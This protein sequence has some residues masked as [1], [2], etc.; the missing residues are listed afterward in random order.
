[1]YFSYCDKDCVYLVYI[2]KK[3]SQNL[4]F[5]INRNLIKKIYPFSIFAYYNIRV[6]EM[7]VTCRITTCYYT[8]HVYSAVKYAIEKVHLQTTK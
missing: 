7:K 1:M 6:F 2:S 3:S 4:E 5:L 8:Y